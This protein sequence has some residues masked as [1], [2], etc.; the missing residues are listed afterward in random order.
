[1]AIEIDVAGPRPVLVRGA[2][3]RKANIL[4]AAQPAPHVS[5]VPG[6]GYVE[7]VQGAANSG[8]KWPV[9]SRLVGYTNALH[10]PDFKLC[11]DTT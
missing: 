6:R 9:N 2:G 5:E 11:L 10:S 1:M 4:H 3:E 7:Q 8:E